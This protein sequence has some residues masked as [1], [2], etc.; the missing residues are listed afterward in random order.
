[1]TASAE[2]APP[3][4]SGGLLS[5]EEAR[6][7]MLTGVEPLGVEEVTLAAAVGRVVAT[8][9]TAR[10]TLPPWDNSSMDGF[11]VR[12][13]DLVGASAAPV[14]LR[15]VG[16]VAAGHPPEPVVER[17]T[18][19]R[20]L[21]GAMIPS[22]ADAVVPVEQTDAQPGVAALP[23][24]VR[25]MAAVA[26]GTHIRERGSDLA[27]GEPVAAR[28]TLV[29]P[30]T[31]ALLAAAG[32]ATV[33]VHR[34]PRVGILG[35]G[36]E[37]V[38]AGQPLANGRIHDSNSVALAAQAA[39]VGADVRELGI[40]PDR[41]EAVVERLEAGLATCDVVIVSGGV[42]V[43]AHDVV[44]EAFARLGRIDLWR[45]AVQPGKPVAFGS[46]G[47]A[48]GRV[49][50][51]GLPGNPVSSFV[52]FELFVRP[53]LRRMTGHGDVVG[54]RIIRA[55]LGSDV[56][57]SPGRRAFIRVSLAPDPSAPSGWRADLAGGQG[58][59]VLSALA[60]ADGLA[61]I[62]EDV[63]GLPAGAEVDAWRFDEEG[64]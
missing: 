36:D 49:L 17:G 12:S 56:S 33:A 52:T 58:S 46:V 31:V 64:T 54:R 25:I 21:T 53:V 27:A 26:P 30:A 2:V 4:A 44:K 63:P 10:V 15:V 13:A 18:A 5:L 41:P 7:R 51:F 28:G 8:A 59:H 22:G 34:R 35:T 11:A 60:A 57:K 29:R 43:G 37:L 62:P 14:E 20:V 23:G 1:M 48:D 6:T 61:V 24:R 38:P 42:S 32:H 40:A 39:A 16:E 19:V 45:V 3:P 9:L 55:T 47:R 50:L